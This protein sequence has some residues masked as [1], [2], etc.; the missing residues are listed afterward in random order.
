MGMSPS[1]Y[2][3]YNGLSLSAKEWAEK[4]CIKR[5]T[6][7]SRVKR[8]E[9]DTEKL[10]FTGKMLHEFPMKKTKGCI[11]DKTDLTG[12]RN[13]HLTVKKDRSSTSYILKNGKEYSR[14][15]CL[16]RCDC[17]V[18]Y[19]INRSSMKR[20]DIKSCKRCAKTKTGVYKTVEVG[21]KI[22]D[23][24]VIKTGVISPGRFASACIVEYP[25]GTRRCVDISNIVNGKFKGQYHK[26]KVVYD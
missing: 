9:N 14:V 6:F 18:E 12:F 25:D 26:K 8:Y 19:E 2:Y 5:S 7:Y 4:L 16:V 3:T 1:K 23:A 24:V 13:G 20:G 15:Y 11:V 22:G 10:F 17:G 21:M